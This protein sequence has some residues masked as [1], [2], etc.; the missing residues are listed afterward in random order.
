MFEHLKKYN[1][2]LVSGPQRS[3]T[4]IAAVMIALDTG[5][6]Y[7][8]ERIFYHDSINRFHYLVYDNEYQHLPMVIQCPGLSHVLHRLPNYDDIAVVWVKRSID[9]IIA[10]QER[11]DWQGEE[12]EW[13]KAADSFMRGVIPI[14]E[15]KYDYWDKF[16]A[17]RIPARFEIHYSAL[18]THPLWEDSREGW[19]SN[20]FADDYSKLANLLVIKQVS[21]E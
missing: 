19:D 16:Q 13:M 9:A 4:R 5:H 18:K 11:I 12:I 21:D 6:Y 2:I 14:S 3:G 1:R 17:N 20:Q 7:T 8:D 15:Y 10:S